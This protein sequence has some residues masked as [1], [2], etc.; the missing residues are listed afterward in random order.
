MQDALH[1][2]EDPV[3]VLANGVNPLDD[4]PRE[5]YHQ[6]VATVDS[7]LNARNRVYIKVNPAIGDGRN[8]RQFGPGCLEL[9][10]GHSTAPRSLTCS[11]APLPFTHTAFFRYCPS[12]RAILRACGP[13]N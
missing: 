7:Y 2:V 10:I 12:K 5:G 9:E 3:I 6:R 8:L 4:K 1:F 13:V 11:A